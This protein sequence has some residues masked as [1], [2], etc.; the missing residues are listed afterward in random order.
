MNANNA[1]SNT[2][3]NNAFGKCKCKTTISPLS[4]SDLDGLRQVQSPADVRAE[5]VRKRGQEPWPTVR[6]EAKVRV[7]RCIVNI[8]IGAQQVISDNLQQY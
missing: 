8:S 3:S 1:P 7:G 4:V 6:L 5:Q 2:N